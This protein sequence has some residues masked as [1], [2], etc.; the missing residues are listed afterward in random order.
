MRST[1]GCVADSL[2]YTQEM[3]W[4]RLLSSS[5][6]PLTRR[7]S[8]YQERLVEEETHA[9]SVKNTWKRISLFLCLPTVGYFA[10]KSLIEGEEHHSYSYIPWSHLRIRTKPFPWG[11]GDTSLFHNTHTNP[12]PDEGPKTAPP[13]QTLSQKVGRLWIQYLHE[14]AVERDEKRWRHLEKMQRR[15]EEQYPI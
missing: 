3:A 6:R 5:S 1:P 4:H 10:W 12:G 15:K 11:D 9:A 2:Y 7:L 8:S 14:D 13:T